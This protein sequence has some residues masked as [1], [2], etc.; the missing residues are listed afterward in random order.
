MRQLSVIWEVRKASHS[1][2]KK[3]SS[4]LVGHFLCFPQ[5]L[6]EDLVNLLSKTSQLKITPPTV[7]GIKAIRSAT[8][9]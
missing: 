5:F 3:G 4:V 8:R 6:P 7:S 9:G 2:R 1:S